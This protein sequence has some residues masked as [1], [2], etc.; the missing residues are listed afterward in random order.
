MFRKGVIFS[1]LWLAASVF[2]LSAGADDDMDPAAVASLSRAEGYASTI[3]WVG[4]KLVVYT[5]DD[6]ITFHLGDN[7][8][9]ERDGDDISVN[10]IDQG[11]LL[12]V[13][14]IDKKLVGLEAVKI[15]DKEP[16]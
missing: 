1:L 11:D 12:T 10:E 16:L 4:S 2:V 8:K 6:E 14:Y 5:G 15:T 9:V 3:D 7:V 13:Y